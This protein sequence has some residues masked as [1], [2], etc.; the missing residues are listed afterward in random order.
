MT[1]TSLL[2]LAAWTLLAPVALSAQV[3]RSG[4]PQ[5]QDAIA[6]GIGQSALEAFR[7]AYG[8]VEGLSDGVFDLLRNDLLSPVFHGIKDQARKYKSSD[9][10][11]AFERTFTEKETRFLLRLSDT[12]HRP[13][14]SVVGGGLPAEDSRAWAGN[15]QVSVVLDSFKDS[16]L[17][18]YQVNQLGLW[19]KNYAQD[20]QN[21][22]PASLT[23]AGVIGGAF[24]YLNGAHN[25]FQAGGLK[26]AFDL[27]G[28]LRLREAMKTGGSLGRAAGI[29]VSVPNHP[30]TFA[31]D[32]GVESGR[33]KRETY[34]FKYHRKF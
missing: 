15:E 33:F 27:R 2:A 3:Y 9:S 12:F 13:S 7:P 31:A 23:M 30:L 14:D 34:G 1:R 18:R 26:F 10:Y 16:L 17:D 20:P 11:G 4:L 8:L 25:H 19:A 5:K 32:W 24:L 21:W 28:A 6:D 29:E 22:D